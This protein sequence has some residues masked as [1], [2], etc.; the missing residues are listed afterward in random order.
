MQLNIVNFISSLKKSNVL[1]NIF[2]FL[3]NYESFMA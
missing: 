1:F 2:F 3:W